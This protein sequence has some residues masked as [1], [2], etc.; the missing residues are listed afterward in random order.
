M[1]VPKIVK[2][3]KRNKV[4][5]RTNRS[6]HRDSELNIYLWRSE[7]SVVEQ[8]IERHNRP[9]KYIEQ[10]IPQI[11][12][13]LEIPFSLDKV[14]IKWDQ[15]CGCSCPC[16]PGFRTNIYLRVCVDITYVWVDVEEGALVKHILH[17]VAEEKCLES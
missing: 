17:E 9:H 10:F 14:E 8:L 13:N 11:L 6:S 3:E 2:I 4:G 12:M 7:E 1:F 5:T 15:Y 16:S